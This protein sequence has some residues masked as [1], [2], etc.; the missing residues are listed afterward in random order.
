MYLLFQSLMFQTLIKKENEASRRNYKHRFKLISLAL[1]STI[2][3]KVN[4]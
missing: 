3:N 1:V 2:L 4:A